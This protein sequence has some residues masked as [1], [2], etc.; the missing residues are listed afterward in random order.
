M[1]L[2]P[3]NLCLSHVFLLVSLSTSPL[4][5]YPAPQKTRRSERRAECASSKEYCNS[6]AP[7]RS[8]GVRFFTSMDILGSKKATSIVI[9]R[10]QLV[11]G[12]FGKPISCRNPCRCPE[13][14][15]AISWWSGLVLGIEHLGLVEGNWTNLLTSTPP[16][17]G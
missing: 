15:I 12:M 7:A 16:I 4:T 13:V 9:T 6:K 8:V 14:H 10:Y 1:S 2:A 5:G 3:S 11:F 17:G